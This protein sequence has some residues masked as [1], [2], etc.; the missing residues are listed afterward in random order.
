MCFSQQIEEIL[1]TFQHLHECFCT[2][3]KRNTLRYF[4]WNY[5]DFNRLKIRLK[6]EK[7]RIKL[8]F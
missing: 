4:L 3:L 1:K 8:I 6:K 5:I 7:L 2:A